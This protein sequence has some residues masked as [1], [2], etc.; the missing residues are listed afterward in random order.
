MFNQILKEL[1]DIKESI[2]G[3]DDDEPTDPTPTK[4]NNKEVKE[5]LKEEQAGAT[6]EQAPAIVEEVETVEEEEQGQAEVITEEVKEEPETIEIKEEQASTIVEPVETVETVE[7]VKEEKEY[8]TMMY[9]DRLYIPEIVIN[10][11]RFKEL[12]AKAKEL[13]FNYYNKSDS[14]IPSFLYKH[15]KK[16]VEEH[17]QEI[18]Y[19]L[20]LEFKKIIPELKLSSEI[21]SVRKFITKIENK[22][23][24]KEELK[25]EKVKVIE[26]KTI[27]GI[28]KLKVSQD[29]KYNIEEVKE[30]EVR[31][32]EFIT[33]QDIEK[34]NEV[35][36]RLIKS[37]NGFV[38]IH[39]NLNINDRIKNCYMNGGNSIMWT[40]K[41]SLINEFNELCDSWYEPNFKS[42]IEKIDNKMEKVIKE[43]NDMYNANIHNLKEQY[44]IFTGYYYDTSNIKDYKE[45]IKY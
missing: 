32:S 3:N 12:K 9:P 36:E 41:V 30:V 40:I 25:E 8:W 43:I 19:T 31:L 14:Y 7:E 4:R 23:N 39:N 24:N 35:R 26:G 6:I 29:F 11:P 17:L 18:V 28:S 27:K 10:H 37:I 13:E 15:R 33:D 38:K 45:I 16:M 44:G 5:D 20:Y 21:S 22:I 42:Q 2:K 1:K 34:L